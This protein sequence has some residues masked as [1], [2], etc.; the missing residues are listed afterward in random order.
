MIYYPIPLHRQDVY[1]DLCKGVSLPV[2]EAAASE[3]ISLPIFPQMTI[4]QVDQ[5]CSVVRAAIKS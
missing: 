5:V 2:S 1:A 3:V 4:D